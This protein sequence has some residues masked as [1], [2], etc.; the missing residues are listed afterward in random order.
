V[1]KST[2]KNSQKVSENKNEKNQVTKK[3]QEA[4]Q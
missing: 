4:T 1:A 3:D 2:K